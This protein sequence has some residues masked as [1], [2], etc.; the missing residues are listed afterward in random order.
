MTL[1]LVAIAA[2]VAGAVNSIAGGEGRSVERRAGVRRL[3]TRMVAAA[4]RRYHQL[5]GMS[6]TEI[7]QVLRNWIEQA[8]SPSGRFVEGVAPVDWVADNFIAWWR[9]EVEHSLNSAEGWA[10]L[11][12][13]DLAPLKDLLAAD[14]AWSSVSELQDALGDLRRKLGL[15]RD[16]TEDG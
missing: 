10:G 6:Q 5:S 11:L 4:N 3:D 15:S 7:H 8:M 14:E 9:T 1:L 12:R 16:T 2:F 13:E